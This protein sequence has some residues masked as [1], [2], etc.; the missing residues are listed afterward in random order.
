MLRVLISELKLFEL[1]LAACVKGFERLQKM[2]I[3]LRMGVPVHFASRR[4]L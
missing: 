3:D 4:D 2:Q 1:K